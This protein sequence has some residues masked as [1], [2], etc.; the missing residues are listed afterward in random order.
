MIYCYVDYIN[1]DGHYHYQFDETSLIE[2]LTNCANEPFSVCYRYTYWR[3]AIP[4]R[5]NAEE[6]SFV[7]IDAY[8]IMLFGTATVFVFKSY[9][10]IINLLHQHR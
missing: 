10:S 5:V 7:L 6:S 4:S 3:P 2:Y 9:L 1:L 8:V